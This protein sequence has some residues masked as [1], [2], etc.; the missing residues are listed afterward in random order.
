MT[1]FD[2]ATTLQTP[3]LGDSHY[4]LANDDE[5]D[6][7]AP[8]MYPHTEQDEDN[9]EDSTL[10][11]D[12]TNHDGHGDKQVSPPSLVLVL[13][14]PDA[15]FWMTLSFKLF[16]IFWA[17]FTQYKEVSHATT[18]AAGHTV[19]VVVGV[20]LTAA[21]VWICKVIHIFHAKNDNTAKIMKALFVLL[22]EIIMM[23]VLLFVLLDKIAIALIIFFLGLLLLSILGVHALVRHVFWSSN[24][25]IEESSKLVLAGRRGS[26]D[27]VMIV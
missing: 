26:L 24:S 10:C 15:T 16:L 8:M 2:K 1:S 9:H 19:F 5:D 13:F 27:C 23:I 12:D 18:A 22:P 14:G 3:L 7:E 25:E 20:A 6:D 4:C 11:H 21:N 17:V